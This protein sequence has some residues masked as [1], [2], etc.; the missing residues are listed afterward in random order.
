[1][2]A[3]PNAHMKITQHRQALNHKHCMQ[4]I[5][6]PKCPTLSTAMPD[7]ALPNRFKQHIYKNY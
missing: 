5:A 6:N 1:M 3:L 2:L 7:T 4:I